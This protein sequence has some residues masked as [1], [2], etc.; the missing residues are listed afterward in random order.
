MIQRNYQ[1][2]GR[3]HRL[4]K[5]TSRPWPQQRQQAIAQAKQQ[6]YKLHTVCYNSTKTRLEVQWLAVPSYLEEDD[7]FDILEQYAAKEEKKNVAN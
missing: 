3:V 1:L 7:L 2:V 4:F 5:N 6:L